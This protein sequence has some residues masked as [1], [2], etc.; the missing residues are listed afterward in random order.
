[1]DENKL[2]YFKKMLTE[3]LDDLY[4]Q[5]GETVSVMASNKERFPDPTDRASLE[6]DRNFELRLRDR[7][8]RL[9]K[10]IEKALQ[11]IDDGIFGICESCSKEIGY[12][13]L[14]A[15]PVTTQCI[16]CK[17]KTEALEKSLGI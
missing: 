7:E 11:R 12:E 14:Q 6:A 4:K 5:A 16:D 9:A 1:M 2:E 15:R 3:Q 8:Y 10:K 17:I 13:R